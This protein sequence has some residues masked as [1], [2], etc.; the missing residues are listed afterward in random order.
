MYVVNP[1]SVGIE[2]IYK[3][4]KK[5]G[6]ILIYKYGLPIFGKSDDAET[7]YFVK[8]K[9]FKKVLG[10]MEE[11]TAEEEGNKENESET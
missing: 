8:T 1:Q 2:F 7:Y 5:M 10:L 3:C 6:E 11:A 9:E 4:D